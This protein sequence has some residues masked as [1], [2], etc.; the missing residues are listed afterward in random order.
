MKK[1]KPII[2]TKEDRD[3]LQKIANTRTEEARRVQRANILLQAADGAT[4]ARIAEVVGMS[5]PSVILCLKKYGDAGW[6]YALSDNSRTGRPSII[7]DEAKIWVRDLACQKPSEY[8]YAQELWSITKLQKHIQKT[9]GEA[10]YAE[11]KDVA[12]SKVWEILNAAEIKPHRIRYYLERRDPEFERKMHDVLLVYKQVELMFDGSGNIVWPD[13][14]SRTI[15]ISYDEKPGIQAIANV[16]EDRPPTGKHGFTARDSEYKRLGTISLLAGI[17]LLTGEIIP[18]ISDNHKSADF[19]AFLKVLN[20]KYDAGDKIRI[21]MDN[22]SIH[23]SKETR[24]YLETV[25][26]RFEFVFTPKHGSWLNLI[27]SFFG[28]LAHVCLRGI[29]VKTKKELVERIYRYIAEVNE[30][31]VVYHWTYKMDEVNAG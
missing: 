17:D 10:G 8:G 14:R 21:I 19:I 9:C 5:R 23:T 15:T 28:K 2:L 7:S 30:D 31:P 27:E 3:A 29:R 25:P 6:E 22:H 26:E 11:L 24:A 13:D 16:A 1:M 4:Q 20:D 12:K 18:R